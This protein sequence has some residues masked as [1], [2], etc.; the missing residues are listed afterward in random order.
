MKTIHAYNEKEHYSKN[1]KKVT[2]TCKDVEEN[3]ML[4]YVECSK[5][6]NF[7]IPVY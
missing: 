7:K 3:G 5:H 1:L 2:T 6:R 4:K